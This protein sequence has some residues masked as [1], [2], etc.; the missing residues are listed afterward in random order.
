VVFFAP[1]IHIDPKSSGVIMAPT[2]KTE[3]GEHIHGTRLGFNV[4]FVA[5]AIALTLAAL[6]RFNVIHSISF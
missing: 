5:I 6:I 4:D 2:Q 1:Y 3:N